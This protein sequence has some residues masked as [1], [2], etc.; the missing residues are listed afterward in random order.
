MSFGFSFNKYKNA[1]S[2]QAETPEGLLKMI[3]Q[4]KCPVEVVQFYFDGSKHIA[5]LITE[6]KIIRK[7][8]QE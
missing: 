8:K 1:I 5:I 7:L 2:L 3:Q 4:I 6:K